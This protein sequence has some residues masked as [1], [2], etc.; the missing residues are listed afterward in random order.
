MLDGSSPSPDTGRAA[1]L[2]R[3]VNLAHVV[4]GRVVEVPG[5]EV[6]DELV[7]PCPSSIV[8]VVGVVQS[9]LPTSQR[10]VHC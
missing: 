2:G 6:E 8:R 1:V 10:N 3:A 7:S 5:F 9:V 4:V